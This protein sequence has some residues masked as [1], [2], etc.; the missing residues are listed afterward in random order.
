M[1]LGVHWIEQGRQRRI[2]RERKEMVSV[3]LKEQR[4]FPPK[5]GRG[6]L[7]ERGGSKRR[8]SEVRAAVRGEAMAAGSQDRAESF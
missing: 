4:L 3:S 1:T 8:Q 7:G 6:R 5:G 2:V